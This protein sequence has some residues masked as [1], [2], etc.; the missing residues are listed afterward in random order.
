MSQSLTDLTARLL[1]AARKAGAEQADAMARDGTSISIGVRAGKLEE[2]ERSEGAEIGLR[3]ILGQRQA[4]VSSSDLRDTAMAE[5]AARAVAMAREAPEDPTVGLAGAEQLSELRTAE[6]LDLYDPSDV[7]APDTLMQDALAA[8]A[9]ALE[10]SGVTQVQSAGAA[11]GSSQVHL[12]ATNGFSGGYGRTH[13]Q[14]YCTA[15]AG[16]G[17]DM[18]R[19]SDGDMRLHQSDLR[20]PAEIGSR[21]GERAVARMGAVQPRTGRYPVLFD[22]RISGSLIGHLLGAINGSAI[23]RGAS[24]L[25]DR[26]GQTI[27]PSALSVIEDPHR[28]RVTGS[29]PFDAEGLPTR[30]R[31]LIDAGV[32]TG[33]TLDLATGR[34]LGMPSTGNAAR[35]LAAPPS[36]SNWNIE[37]TQ[38]SASR[39]DLIAQMGTGFLVTSLIGSTINPNTGD[40]SRGASGFWVENGQIAYPVAEATIAGNL[41]EMLARII[42]ANDARAHLSHVVPSILIEDMSIAGQ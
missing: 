24:F 13:R 20:S 34:K 3:V 26:M 19:D 32:L 40:Y 22:E 38:G 14:T 33:W 6:G 10:V 15:I 18:E 35:G 31:A 5:M 8:E 36:P 23:A 41:I 11:Y 29:R 39:D 9:A 1:D 25:R 12:A 37:L 28:A 17:T 30:R 42:P 7:P 4:C 21:A 2:A 16:S 27:L